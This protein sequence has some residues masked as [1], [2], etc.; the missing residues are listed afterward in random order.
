M[1]ATYFLTLFST[2]FRVF[3]NIGYSVRKDPIRI[4]TDPD[5]ALFPFQDKLKGTFQF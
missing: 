5:L 1:W 4:S 3:V 2:F